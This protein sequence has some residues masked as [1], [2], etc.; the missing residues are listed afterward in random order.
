MKTKPAKLLTCRAL[1]PVLRPL[2][3]P[4]AEVVELDIG[5]HLSPEGL[6][7]ELQ[8]RV[9]SLETDGGHILLGY[10]LCGRA[11]EG[12]SS[13]RSR[14][15]LPRVDDC[16]GALLGSRARHRHLLR[17][18]AGRYF[19]TPQWLDSEMNIFEQLAGQMDRVPPARRHELVKLTLKHYDALA[20][21]H[22]DDCDPADLDRGRALA[23]AHGLEFQAHAQ[24]LGLL[25]RLV[26]GPWSDEE[27]VM[28]EPGRPITLF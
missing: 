28:P 15:V 2:L 1:A 16:V 18:H 9:E 21:V 14:L 8:A 25:G 5:L 4:D 3:G 22:G 24:D 12:V 10:G 26:L 7:R 23:A 17:Q 27:F 13:R 20:F 19:M 6:R 11:L